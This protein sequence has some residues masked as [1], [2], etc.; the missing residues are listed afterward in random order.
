M[1]TIKSTSCI[2]VQTANF[3]DCG[4]ESNQKIYS[5]ARIE[6][7]GIETF[8]SPELECSSHESLAVVRA[9]K[10]MTPCVSVAI[11]STAGLVNNNVNAYSYSVGPYFAK[12]VLYGT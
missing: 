6:S 2:S 5:V 4:I 10:Y 7:N 11:A 3:S 8:F 12:P 9:S 1:H